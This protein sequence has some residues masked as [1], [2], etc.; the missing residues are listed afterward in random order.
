MADS[1]RF[2]GFPMT[3][4]DSVQRIDEVVVVGRRYKEVIPAQRLQGKEL[5]VLNSFSV[6]D[7]VRYFAGV[8]LKDYGGVGGLK[9]VN[10][11]SMGTNHTG[12]FYDGF[13]VGN[14][15]NG[16]VDLGK[17]SLDN[18]EAVSL[19]NGQKSDI[20]QTARDY[21]SAASLYL[22]TKRPVFL[23]GRWTNVAGGFKT[24]SFG[25][26]NPSLRVEHRL[27][28]GIAVTASSEVTHAHGRYRFRYYRENADGTPAYDTTAVRENGDIHAMR[29]ECGLLGARGGWEWN[30]QTYH[31]H[32]DRG[33]PGAIVNNV[34]KR[35]ERQRDRN[36]FVQGTV[37]GNPVRWLHLMTKVKYAYDFMHYV[38]N[39]VR[40]L[41][42][43]QTYRQQEAYA[44]QV[45]MFNLLGKYWDMALAYD[46][47]WNTLLSRDEKLNAVP[48]DF[49]YPRRYTHLASAATAFEFYG[50]RG[51][52]SV[53]GTF[54]RNRVE[55]GW[56]GEDRNVFSPAAFLSYQPFTKVPL[57]A[58]A[59][60]KHS[61]RMPT[62]ND[63]YY[64]EIGNANLKPEYVT[65]YNV[66][67]QYDR[68]RSQGFW[69]VLNATVDGYYNAVEDKIVAYPKGQQF[70][71][72]ML[73]LGHVEIRGVDVMLE[74]M[75]APWREL[76]VTTKLQYTYQRAQ[77]FTDPADSFYGDQIPYIPWHSGSAILG[78]GFRGISLNYSFIYVGERYSQS[79]NIVY[80]HMLPWYTSDVSLA[81]DLEWRGAEF[82]FLAEVNN[83]LG[84]DYDVIV[85]YPMPGRNYRFTVRVEI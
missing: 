4:F 69:R 68:R 15:Q 13:A 74:A 59:F 84:Q 11:R 42:L 30:L 60:Y 20:F 19:Y 34:W 62:F 23:N 57:R 67:L 43:D 25:L 54:V 76:T 61:F 37:K 33:M 53:L 5:E 75:M 9:T 40:M 39:D 48:H 73:N 63:L 70:R 72:T 82:R 2:S 56:Q 64:T 35:E 44:S 27:A 16:Q 49:P 41:K 22:Q 58:H 45:V 24:G 77:D 36:S 80:N 1:V 50:L 18:V 83:L 3:A 14:A 6:A 32:S 65:Q 7:A 52:V 26:L 66:G 46:F 21:G 31:Y 38:N 51:Q 47:H 29:F 81:Y 79:E 28:P 55:R 71:W 78:L 17:F 12:V 10:I 8:Q 85:N